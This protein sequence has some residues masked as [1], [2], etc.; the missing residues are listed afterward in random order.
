[1]PFQG[2]TPESPG[3][4]W[5]LGRGDTRDGRG[6]KQTYSKWPSGNVLNQCQKDSCKWKKS[7][8]IS[9]GLN[10]ELFVRVNKCVCRYSSPNETEFRGLHRQKD[11]RTAQRTAGF[12]CRSVGGWQHELFPIFPKPSNASLSASAQRRHMMVWTVYLHFLG[13]ALT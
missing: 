10:G 3:W 5:G 8:I 4:A 7:C 9:L 1:M 12:N 13:I 2:M 11:R 6:H